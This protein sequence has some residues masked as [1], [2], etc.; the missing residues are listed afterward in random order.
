MPHRGGTRKLWRSRRQAQRL[1]PDRRRIYGNLAFYLLALQRF[2]EARQI[3]HE[4]QARTGMDWISMH[5]ALYALAF[6]GS[7]SAAMAEQQQWFAGKPEYESVGFALHPTPRRM[8]VILASA[9]ELT[10]RAVDSAVQA[11]QQGKGGNMA[12]DAA[13][14]REAAYG[15]P[16][17]ARQISGRGF[18]ACSHESRNRKRS[19]ACVRHGGRYG[20]SRVP[21]ARLR[22]A[23]P[24]GHADAVALAARDSGAIGTGQKESGSRPESSAGCHFPHRV[25]DH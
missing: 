10:K 9:R 7:D 17:E 1:G 5:N 24:A 12:G 14:Q 4:A 18:E 3:I 13:A 22:E 23:L 25:G 16:A 8:G 21:G 6:L 19:R 11:D 2:D 15:N 20:T